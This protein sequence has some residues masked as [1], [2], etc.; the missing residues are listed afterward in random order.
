MTVLDRVLSVGVAVMAAWAGMAEETPKPIVF[1][2]PADDE[3][4]VMILG[5]G[6]VGATVWLDAA[7]TFHTVLQN[8]DSWNEGGRHVT[9]GAID[10]ET[11]CAVDT[12]TFRQELSMA[13]GEF[14]ASW[15]S[16]GKPVSLRYRI[17]QGTDSIAVCDVRGT[18]KAEAKVVNWRLYPGGTKAFGVGEYG[19][20]NRFCEGQFQ[21]NVENLT[22]T[23]NADRL[24]S[25]G[26]CHVNR[27]ETVVELMKVYDYYQA[28]GD[29]GKPDLLSNRV[30]GGITR[31]EKGEDRI[32]FLTAVTCLHPCK[33]AAEWERRTRD[34]LAKEGWALVSEETKR[35]EHV[36]AW[37]KFWDRSHIAISPTAEAAGQSNR[38]VIPTNAKLPVSFGVDSAGGNRFRGR[39]VSAEVAFN[40]RKVYSGAPKAG[41][42]VECRIEEMDPCRS[43]H[44]ACRFM[45]VD[46]G[47]PQR[48]LD[49]ITPGKSDGFLVDLLNGRVRLIVGRRIVSHSA[50]V[51]SGREVAVEVT[52][53][54]SGEARIVVDHAAETFDFG[55]ATVAEE[56]AAVTRAYAAQRYVSACAGR[57]RLPI[58]FN[59]SIFTISYKGDPDYRR[60][61][62]GYWW[63][64]T[65]LPYYPMFAAGD[66]DMLQPLFRMY[67]GFRDFNMK[68]TR[69]YL[70][71]GGAYFPECT[72]PWGDHF[73]GSYGPEC[74]WKDRK[75][76]LQHHPCHKYE[77]VGQ[78]EFSLMLLY[79]HAYT[80]DDAWFRANALPSIR[81]YVRY[82]D[83]HYTLDERGH[84]HMYPAQAVETWQDC[85][86]PMP[87]VAGLMRVTDLLLALPDGALEPGD[88][89]LFA[90]IRSRIP[91]LPTRKL[92]D[93]RIIYAPGEKFAQH[94]NV[95]T[96]E[97]YCVFPFRLSSFE[98]PNVEMGRVTYV[99]RYH[100]HYFGWAQDE[101]NAA[102]LGLAEEA[103]EHIADRALT[104]SNK[105]YRWPTYWGP[106]FDWCPDQDEGGVF[107]NTIQSMLMQHE[108]KTI[109]LLPAWPKE[110]NCSFK[111]HAPY[112][113]TIEGRV[114]NGT[115]KDLTVD[116]PSRRGDVSIC[117]VN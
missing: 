66:L 102:Y 70:G 88:R 4:G 93:G 23:V 116:P 28:T 30:F 54:Q 46:T 60:W 96:P 77:W 85:T 78:L 27:N 95:E 16:G 106:N 72:Q 5:N 75:D 64:N 67:L 117:P 50:K 45:T 24:V 1:D 48:L 114:E 11:G 38:F 80:Q 87:E 41:D 55:I 20:G 84:Y 112:N 18:S 19:L 79:Y 73:I 62:S 57:G 26:W 21:K 109:F 105:I 6:E 17:Q 111:L 29:L 39:F 98:K 71:H 58:R 44:F 34:R 49:N 40:G 103:R 3:R 65:R 31:A 42:K 52:V 59:G 69:K 110:W 61:G 76:K 83:E 47:T 100:K 81:E 97:L 8:S 104:H 36:A 14:E 101:L 68:R 82:F 2:S 91:E 51:P 56:C 63:Q 89:E 33:D 94:R 37:A 92:G 115:V 107:Q 13:R 10:Y 7:G 32:F 12:G 53:P 43:L 15:K 99:N 113:T 74:E 25:D 86:N 9:T 35:A 90:K 22:F 108:G